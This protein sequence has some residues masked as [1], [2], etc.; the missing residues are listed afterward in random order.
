MGFFDLL[1]GSSNRKPMSMPVD[2]FHSTV[3]PNGDVVSRYTPADSTDKYT[4]VRRKKRI[5]EYHSYDIED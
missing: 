4:Q 3:A 2:D 1:A 5:V